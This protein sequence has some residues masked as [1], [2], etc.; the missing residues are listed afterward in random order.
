MKPFSK[1]NLRSPCHVLELL[2]IRGRCSAIP[3]IATAD[4]VTVR[5]VPTLVLDNSLIFLL[6]ATLRCDTSKS[7]IDVDINLNTGCEFLALVL[8][9]VEHYGLYFMCAASRSAKF[10][11][12]YGGSK[13]GIVFLRCIVYDKPVSGHGIELL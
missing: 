9:Y 5:S 4:D 10:E 1:E 3:I 11:V 7:V 2:A 8:L 6:M 13:Q 12:D